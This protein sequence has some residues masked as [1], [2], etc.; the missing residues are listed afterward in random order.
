MNKVA[1]SA[2]SEKTLSPKDAVLPEDKHTAQKISELRRRHRLTPEEMSAITSVP[3]DV[4]RRLE[5]GKSAVP[6]SAV[7]LIS[8][9]MGVAPDELM[10]IEEA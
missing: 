6:A 7:F 9:S 2:F 3:A 5:S 4:I 1:V 10:D 8:Y